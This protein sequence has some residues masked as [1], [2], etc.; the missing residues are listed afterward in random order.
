MKKHGFTLIELMVVIVIMGTLAA[1]A[2]PKLFSAIAKSK[3]SEIG[4]AAGTYIKLQDAYVMSHNNGGNWQHIG[5]NSPAGNAIDKARS[6]S[7]EYDASQASYNWSATAL[8]TMNDC[9]PGKKWFINYAFDN[10]T[11]TIKFWASS[12]DEANCSEALTPSYKLLSTTSTAITTPG[13]AE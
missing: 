7:F 12:D 10:D 8:S 3:A 5:Y 13:N 4:P 6:A 1:I 11:K 2:V 9:V